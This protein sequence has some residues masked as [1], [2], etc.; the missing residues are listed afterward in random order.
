MGR[1]RLSLA[2]GQTRRFKSRLMLSFV[3]YWG[4][5][6]VLICGIIVAF[7]LMLLVPAGMSSLGLL[8]KSG[9]MS[10][11]SKK[12]TLLSRP[13]PTAM[14]HAQTVVRDGRQTVCTEARLEIMR[15]LLALSDVMCT[16]QHAAV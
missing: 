10:I 15:S 3:W 6:V 9:Q 1:G 11:T 4:A 16:G 2:S 8:K 7:L 5:S 12:V 14:A 13:S